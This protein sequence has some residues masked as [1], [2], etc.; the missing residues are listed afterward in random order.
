MCRRC[1]RRAGARSVLRAPP[2]RSA[3]VV[4]TAFRVGV[5][6]A[7]GARYAGRSG[8]CLGGER[9]LIRRKGEVSMPRHGANVCPKCGAWGCAFKDP[10]ALLVACKYCGHEWK[11]RSIA[12]MRRARKLVQRAEKEK[13]RTCLVKHG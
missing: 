4:E 1:R 8:V 13:I 10:A 3:G 9:R 2:I 11:T 7:V 6:G 5:R 12:A